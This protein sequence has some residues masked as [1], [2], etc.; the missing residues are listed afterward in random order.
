MVLQVYHHALPLLRRDPAHVAALEV[1]CLRCLV[2]VVALCRR[3]KALPHDLTDI[4]PVMLDNLRPRE[5]GGC[6]PADYMQSPAVNCNAC[7]IVCRFGLHWTRF[8]S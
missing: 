8:Y 4:Q 1:A 2:E 6:N 3:N 7:A 5:R